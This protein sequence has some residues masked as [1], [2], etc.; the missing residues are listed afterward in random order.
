[1][2]QARITYVPYI[3]GRKKV[4]LFDHQKEAVEIFKD[5]DDI[6]LFFEMGCGKTA[7]LLKIAEEKFKNGEMYACCST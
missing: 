1:M 6:A 3:E 7:T 4:N 5:K 2:R